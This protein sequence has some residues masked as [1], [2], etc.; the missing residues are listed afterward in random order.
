MMEADIDQIRAEATYVV[1][2][3]WANLKQ[4]APVLAAVKLL[5]EK[6]KYCH[7]PDRLH[8]ALKR[9][10]LIGAYLLV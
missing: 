6:V 7:D 4:A 8:S 10:T 2:L 3:K 9:F 1:V 5:L